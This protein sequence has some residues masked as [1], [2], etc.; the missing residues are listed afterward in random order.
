[1]YRGVRPNAQGVI[2]LS[3]APKQNYAEVNA[4]EVLDEGR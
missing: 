4:V 1:V 3:L 2:A